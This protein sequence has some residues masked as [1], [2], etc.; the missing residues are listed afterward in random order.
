MSLSCRPDKRSIK[1]SHPLT[2]KSVAAEG[3]QKRLCQ[4]A[5]ACVIFSFLFIQVYGLPTVRK[6]IQAPRK[7]SIAN[8]QNYG[9]EPN[10]RQL[11]N[12]AASAEQG[13]TQQQLEQ[14]LSFDAIQ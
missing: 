6:D 1:Q 3:S 10:S 14:L 2:C 7:Q 11:I 4:K 13:V 9:N 5:P 12:P 8:D